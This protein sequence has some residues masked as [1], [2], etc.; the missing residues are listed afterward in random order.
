MDAKTEYINVMMERGL[1]PRRVARLTS[2]KF[3]EP[4]EDIVL[5]IRKLGWYMPN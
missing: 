5:Q 2:K 3:K 1:S 4:I